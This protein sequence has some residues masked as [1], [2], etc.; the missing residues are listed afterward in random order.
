MRDKRLS[1]IARLVAITYWLS[2]IMV[3]YANLGIVKKL[4]VFSN[5]SATIE[6]LAQHESLFRLA[7]VL[8]LFY[9]IT[10]IVNLIAMYTLFKPVSTIGSLLATSLKLVMPLTWIF[11]AVNSFLALRLVNVSDYSQ[12]FG[13]TGLNALARLTLSGS[14]TYYI[15]LLF[16]SLAAT[17]YSY[18][19]FRSHYIPRPL[20]IFG[21]IA[22]LW[23]F[24]CTI[25]YMID[26]SFSNKVNLWW[27]DSPMVIFELVVSTWLL[28][29]ISVRNS[30]Q[31]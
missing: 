21:I 10:T 5:M 2:T 14:G 27:F 18:L 11:I 20:S 22:S 26:P 15:G 16:W 13:Q 8:N 7:I 29:G 6:N 12:A 24:A 1:G 9:C 30:V 28:F 3:V 23:C 19:F 4:V 17:V 31:V 25:A